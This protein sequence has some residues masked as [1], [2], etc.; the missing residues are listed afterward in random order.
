M[1][2][3]DQSKKKLLS[4]FISQILIKKTKV[5]EKFDGKRPSHA[6]LQGRRTCT[7]ESSNQSKAK[8]HTT[9]P[10]FSLL[11]PSL[12]LHRGAHPA[13]ILVDGLL[14]VVNDVRG[15]GGRGASC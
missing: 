13:V 1:T 9:S 10:V 8:L 5:E 2:Q 12:Q 4:D 14:E 7:A 11:G 6:R 3:K 15:H